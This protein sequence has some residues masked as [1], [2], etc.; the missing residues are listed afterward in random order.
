[1]NAHVLERNL[2]R[3]KDGNFKGMSLVDI[4]IELKEELNQALQTLKMYQ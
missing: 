3:I 2:K 4:K 1:M